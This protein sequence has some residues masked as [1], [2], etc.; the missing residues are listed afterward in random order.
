V[1]VKNQIIPSIGCGEEKQSGMNNK[2]L[3]L[4]SAVCLLLALGSGVLLSQQAISNTKRITKGAGGRGVIDVEGMASLDKKI[5][6]LA[7]AAARECSQALEKAIDEG[8]KSEEEIFS[9]LYFPI[10]PVTSPRTFH[11]FYD[12]YTD[13]VI[14]PIEDR[15]LEKDK[16]IVFVVL[17]DRN[18]YLPSHNS[19][20]SQPRIGNPEVDI[21]RN[22][23]KRIFND[24][25]GFYAAKNREEFLLQVYRRDTGE[26]MADL[27]VPVLVKSRHWGALRIGFLRDR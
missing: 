3:F 14:T 25:T 18:G 13:K 6:N 8:I 11:T 24:I 5:L 21:K 20:F 4:M 9:T 2:Y 15:Y 23:T 27:S 10:K 12:D 1:F 26:F 22:R 16:S 7:K 19:K 17:V